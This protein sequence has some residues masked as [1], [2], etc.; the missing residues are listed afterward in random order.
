MWLFS[1]PLFFLSSFF[2]P[3]P[4]PLP[5]FLFFFLGWSI[6]RGNSHPVNAGLHSFTVRLLLC[7]P[8]RHIVPPPTDAHQHRVRCFSKL[9]LD[10]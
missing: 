6:I 10:P 5:Y 8:G 1:F 3:K 9:S 4:P 7:R 2:F